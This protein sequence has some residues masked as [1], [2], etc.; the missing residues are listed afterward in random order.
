MATEPAGNDA[1]RV[2]AGVLPDSR[3]EFP[4]P[5]LKAHFT[6]RLRVVAGAV[7]DPKKMS[8]PAAAI[9]MKR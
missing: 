9:L 4:D 7:H 8:G 6:W 1:A 3:R 2:D 5:H